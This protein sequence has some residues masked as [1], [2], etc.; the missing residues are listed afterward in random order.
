MKVF[1]AVSVPLL[2]SHAALAQH[3]FFAVDPSASE[4][5][6][7]LHTNHDIVNGTFHVQSGS[8]DFDPGAQKIRGIVV[9]AAGTG[10]TG[11][12]SRDKKMNKDVLKVDQFSTVTFAPKTFTGTLTSKGDS[13]I[14]V[15]GVFTLLGAQHDVTI[16]MEVHL[17]ASKG[18]ASAEFTVPYVRWGLKNPGFLMWK[19][20]NDVA[21]HL[22][23]N[24]QVSNE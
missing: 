24:G 2:L 7:T 17:D 5:R 18:T 3:Q 4:V 9:I 14:Q 13:T 20:D 10:K 8:I 21:I 19:A 1:A 11:N 23:L 16:P 22:V 15:S 6:M 12:D